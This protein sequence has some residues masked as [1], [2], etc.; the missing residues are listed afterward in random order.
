MTVEMVVIE[1]DQ[2]RLVMYCGMQVEK[3]CG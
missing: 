2:R 1:R 3:V